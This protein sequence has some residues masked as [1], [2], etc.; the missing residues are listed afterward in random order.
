[1]A[2]DMIPG[3]RQGTDLDRQRAGQRRRP[4]GTRRRAPQHARIVKQGGQLVF[5]D[6]GV[7]A[8]ARER[9]ARRTEP[10]GPVRLPHA[11]RRSGQGV[12]VPLSHPAIVLMIMARG[13]VH[14]A[15]GASRHRSRGRERVARH[16]ELR[17]QRQSR[18]RDDGPHDGPGQ[19]LDE[20]H[21]RRRPAHPRRTRP[22]RSIRTA[23]SRS[24]RSP[25]RSRSSVS[26]RRPS[27]A[28]RPHMRAGAPAAAP[29]PLAALHGGPPGARGT[30]RAGAGAAQ[31]PHR[32]R[33]AEARS[34]PGRGHHDRPHAGQRDRRPAPAGLERA[35]AQITNDGRPAL[36]RRSRQR[37]RHVRPR[38]APRARAR[39]SPSRTARRSSSARCRC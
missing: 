6:A 38:P 33:R 25:S 27:R 11:V 15:A 34:A 10:A 19:R 30:R 2:A 8:F 35:H 23:S 1:M 36:P 28:A 39:R 4:P 29:A 12:P 22:C 16:R 26:S 37:Q 18:D 9:R 31:A 32:H 20:R 5:F 13:S 17:G 3:L 21:L 7:G 24:V 14:R